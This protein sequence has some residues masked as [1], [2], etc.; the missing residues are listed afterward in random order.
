MRITLTLTMIALLLGSTILNADVPRKMSFQG[1]VTNSSGV[2][3]EGDYDILFQIYDVETGGTHLWEA[4]YLGLTLE[5]GVFDV[6]LGE[7]TPLTLAFDQQYWI[8]ITVPTGTGN[9][10]V[11]RTKLTTS[12]YAFHAQTADTAFSGVMSS[13]DSVLKVQAVSHQATAAVGNSNRA[14]TLLSIYSSSGPVT[15]LTTSD[16]EIQPIN[17]QNYVKDSLGPELFDGSYTLGVVPTTVWVSGANTMFV[18]VTAPQGKGLV[19]VRFAIQ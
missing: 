19:A 13:P 4:T 9:E 2:P 18:E 11:P 3:L 6:I 17:G 1:F 12:P 15:G 7:T 5:G 14:I 8:G 16:V 10:L